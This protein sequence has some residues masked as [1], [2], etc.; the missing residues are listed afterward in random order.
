MTEPGV[1][2]DGYCEADL[3]DSFPESFESGRACTCE[4]GS[5][6]RTGCELCG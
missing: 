3:S 5:D 1:E 4:D 6:S 2:R